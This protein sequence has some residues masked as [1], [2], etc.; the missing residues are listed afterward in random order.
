MKQR[1]EMVA[2]AQQEFLTVK[3]VQ[4]IL[5][6]GRSKAYELFESKELPSI[7]IGTVY[8]V[9][10]ADFDEWVSEQTNKENKMEK[11]YELGSCPRCQKTDL[12]ITDKK[13]ICK[14]CNNWSWLEDARNSSW[15]KE[16]NKE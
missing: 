6:I 7:K 8:R 14:S 16:L 3:D 11:E 10:R 15:L 13:I 4:E 9:S 5:H 1:E 2:L 12:V